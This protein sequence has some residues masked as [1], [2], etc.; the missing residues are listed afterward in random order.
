M[1]DVLGLDVLDL[2]IVTILKNRIIDEFTEMK[3][4]LS[5]LL[6]AKQE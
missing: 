6:R 4:D 5:F 2:E 1:E 3:R